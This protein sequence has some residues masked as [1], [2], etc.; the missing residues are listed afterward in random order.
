VIPVENRPFPTRCRP[1]G[2]PEGVRR[3]A[4]IHLQWFSDDSEDKSEQP[5]EHKL[6]KLREEE[7]QVPKSQEVGSA[8]TLFLPA[9]LLLF[10]A[11]GMLATF[12]EMFRFFFT[13]LTDLNPLADRMVAGLFFRYL[14]RLTLPVLFVAVIAALIS[15][16]VQ[17]GVMFATKPI[18][19]DFKRVTPRFGQFLKRTF[20]I[21]GVFNLLKS[22]FKM[23][24][25][26][27]VSFTLI[28][29]DFDKLINL[30]KA[31]LELGL[32]VIASIAVRMLILCSLLL[33]I[34]SIPDLLFQRWR[35]R[36]RNKMSRHDI[37]EEFKH[38]EGDQMVKGRIRSRFQQMLKQNIAQVVPKADV[39][40]TSP[41][42]YA[43]VLEYGMGQMRSPMVTAKGQDNVAAQIRKLARE[44][45]VPM[46]ENKPLAQAL[47]REVDVGECIPEAYFSVV[48]TIFARVFHLNEKRKLERAR[49]EAAAKAEAE[50]QRETEELLRGD[51]EDAGTNPE[52]SDGRETA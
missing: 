28:R 6:R 42:H 19:P 38:L 11:P 24:L 41:T 37:K 36:E 40:I 43:V 8:A 7:G 47:Y 29:M 10:I 30:Q 13:R 33:M 12:T 35:F 5:T 9:I 27:G 22:V 46:V 45:G 18:V 2:L 1:E 15:N 20:S 17:V 39:V 23:A 52:S 51:G 49:T 44:N 14:L 16:Y 3:A 34:L 25:I 50:A 32:G 4:A 21:E 48:G 26:G 31:G